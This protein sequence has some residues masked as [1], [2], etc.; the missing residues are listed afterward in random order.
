MT[1]EYK[2]EIGHDSDLRNA[3]IQ[4]FPEIELDE[5]TRE[6]LKMDDE[7]KQQI[8][9]K[10]PMYISKIFSDNYNIVDDGLIGLY[11][12]AKEIITSELIEKNLSFI[13]P[14]FNLETIQLSEEAVRKLQE[15]TLIPYDFKELQFEYTNFDPRL[16]PQHFEN[17]CLEILYLFSFN[18][19]NAEMIFNTDYLLEI[20]RKNHES[21]IDLLMVA[22]NHSRDL[23]LFVYKKTHL[24]GFLER[25]YENPQNLNVKTVVFICEKLLTLN[26]FGDDAIHEPNLQGFFI[27][28]FTST[29]EFSTKLEKPD[30]I[31]MIRL[32]TRFA[33]ADIELAHKICST[34][35]LSILDSFTQI[36]SDIN[37]RI[38]KLHE[39]L[40]KYDDIATVIIG[41][42]PSEWEFIASMLKECNEPRSIFSLFR[43]II[44]LMKT[45]L[46]SIPPGY[47]EMLVTIL[48]NLPYDVHS[49]IET[50][51]LFVFYN[52][53]QDQ[54]Q[55]L[56]GSDF[57]IHFLTLDPDFNGKDN[58]I[59]SVFIVVL[60][61]RINVYSGGSSDI[62]DHL[63][64]EDFIHWFGEFNEEFDTVSQTCYDELHENP[65]WPK[66]DE[67][68][69]IADDFRQFFFS[70]E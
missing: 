65:K 31:L 28:F 1:D 40:L 49:K 21:P 26:Y 32:Y 6:M 47:L 45:D 69:T 54:I 67:A 11:M 3:D 7:E 42:Q 34:N 12:T 44:K 20:D 33:E 24:M 46:N 18:K 13:P 10:F 36:E 68:L 15:L 52:M 50:Q 16:T 48:L 66:Y 39:A 5:E 60:A 62:L 30:L 38:I 37:Y 22:M 41:R 59:M 57:F 17:N 19:E 58:C 70:Q 61:S 55:F 35:Y 23:C 29:Y 4:Q 14:D 8:I 53:S 64:N 43:A 25:W 9:E 2:E 27:N 63:F 51:F 56:M